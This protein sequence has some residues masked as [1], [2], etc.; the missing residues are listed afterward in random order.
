VRRLLAFVVIYDPR[1]P[2]HSKLD[3]ALGHFM[4]YQTTKRLVDQ[5][6]VAVVG[7]SS[8]PQLSA[9][10]PEDEPLELALWVVLD[11][12]GNIIRREG[13]YANSD[14]GMR[15]VRQVIASRP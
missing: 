9:F 3:Y 2:T 5:H 12:D 13:I 1:H 14:E 7:P 11:S 6:F 15:R 10:V 8:D 4:E